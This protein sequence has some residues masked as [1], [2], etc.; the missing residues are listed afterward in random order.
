MIA[1][2]RIQR[3]SHGLLPLGFFEDYDLAILIHTTIRA[4]PVRQDRLVAMRAV[5]HLNRV[6]MVVASAFAFAG[7]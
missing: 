3:D 4:D 6:A 1:A 2:H 7:T 5:L